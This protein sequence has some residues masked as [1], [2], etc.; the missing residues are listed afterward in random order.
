MNEWLN[1]SLLTAV[2]STP[3]HWDHMG[4][5]NVMWYV[6]KFDKAS[7]QLLARSGLTRTRCAREGRGAVVL[8]QRIDYRRELHAG[9]LITIRSRALEGNEKTLCMTHEMTN[10]ETGEPAA[11]TVIVGHHIDAYLRRPVPCRL[12]CASAPFSRPEA[13]STSIPPLVT[14]GRPRQPLLISE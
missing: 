11:V 3:W 2:E 6:G 9:D 14:P 8:D 7:W 13:I 1:S 4:H 10:D 12:M 5:M